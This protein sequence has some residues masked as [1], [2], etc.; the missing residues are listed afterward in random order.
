M[1]SYLKIFA[2][3]MAGCTT[4]MFLTE[5]GFRAAAAVCCAALCAIAAMGLLHPLL[6]LIAELSALSGIN[7]SVFAPVLKA[8][9]IGIL[10]RIGAAYCS[11]AGEK[12]MADM[13]ELGGVISILYVSLP[14]FTAVLEM[15]KT[16]M[17]G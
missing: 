6:D 11:D 14:L 17:E 2:L 12:A 3:V 13:L 10:T 9:A 7:R 4:A 8:G 15:L 16:L 5:R 1:E